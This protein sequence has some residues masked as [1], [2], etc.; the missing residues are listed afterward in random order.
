MD[1]NK[2]KKI[3]KIIKIVAIALIVIFLVYSI[4]FKK[5][6]SGKK[7]ANYTIDKIT[8]RQIAN[9]ISGV[10]L[11]E[12]ASSSTVTSSSL[13]SKIKEVYVRE[14]DYVTEGT[15]ICE[16]ETSSLEE[17]I[18]DLEKT[19][20]DLKQDSKNAQKA[21]DDA[22]NAQSKEISELEA[23]TNEA[24]EKYDKAKEDLD[25]KKE[26]D[27]KNSE[28]TNTNTNTNL[29]VNDIDL[30][31]IGNMT[32]NEVRNEITS[33][34][35]Y[36]YTQEE[37]EL[38]RLWVEYQSAQSR[39][40]TY[41]TTNNLSGAVSVDNS[42]VLSGYESQ[43][44]TLKNQLANTKVK[45]TASG[46]I[47]SLSVHKGDTYL[48][49]EIAKI[50]GVDTFQIAAQIDEFNIPD[51]KVGMKVRIKTDATRDQELEGYVTYVS[52]AAISAGSA[53]SIMSS[54]ASVSPMMSSVSA[55]TSKAKYKVTI[56]IA[57]PNERLRIGMNAKIS[58]ITEQKEDALTI[59][60][61]AVQERDDGSKYILVV[62]DIIKEEGKED[63][64]ETEEVDVTVGIEGTYYS[65]I[66]SDKI[67][68]GMDVYITTGTKGES[69]ETLIDIM[70]SEAGI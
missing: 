5:T 6:D 47:T 51:V 35:N 56:S 52:P 55:T 17:Q 37:A 41:K 15:L 28:N 18:A 53:D 68:E 2:K 27:K 10:G 4:F 12:S 58:I 29:N 24:K 38:N 8:K 22:R 60:Y 59:P 39:L 50:E 11:V 36:D 42:S 25:K 70:G 43:L 14:G 23:K 32:V 45:A 61:D 64:I 9:S 7:T 49:S 40:D 13:G 44:R 67:K 3:K 65:E 21:I 1:K 26:E 31:E 57:T 66:I 34:I 63:K 19:I 48:G 33:T 16:F 20:R 62:K 54:L 69:I 46:T 30:N